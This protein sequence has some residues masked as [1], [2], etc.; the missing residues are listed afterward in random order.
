MIYS[1]KRV[2][3]VVPRYTGS[4]GTVC[5]AN[6]CSVPSAMLWVVRLDATAQAE[7]CIVSLWESELEELA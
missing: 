1:G 4:V 7:A 6:T 5:R 2:S 3:V